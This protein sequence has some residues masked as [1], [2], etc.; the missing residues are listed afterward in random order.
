MR[1]CKL[2]KEKLGLTDE[3]KEVVQIKRVR[4]L[5]EKL[6]TYTV[7]Y[8]SLR[9]GRR[10]SEGDLYER[11]LLQILD[12]EMGIR[13]TEAVQKIEAS[14]AD[15]EVAEKLEILSGSPILFVERIMYT[16][17]QHPVEIFQSSYPGNLYNFTVRFKNVR[18]KEG[19]KWIHRSDR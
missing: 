1:S 12:Q 19:G 14:F 17:K 8:L 6:F 2:V 5:R 16:Q 9:I 3:E 18:S 10:I 7:N 4:I 15:E 13:F 11:P